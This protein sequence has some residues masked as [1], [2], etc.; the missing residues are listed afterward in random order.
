MQRITL[1]GKLMQSKEAAH[2]YIAAAFSFPAYYGRNLDALYD[3]LSER[4][5]QPLEVTLINGDLLREALG[6]YGEGI[7]ACFTDAFTKP[8]GARFIEE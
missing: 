2:A 6:E 1:D 4:R 7:V 5:R 3:L 8:N